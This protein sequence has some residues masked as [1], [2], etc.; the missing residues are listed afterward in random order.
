M[1]HQ[2]PPWPSGVGFLGL[3]LGGFK[4]KEFKGPSKTSLF[5]VVL[6][7]LVRS[8]SR[9]PSVSQLEL[10]DQGVHPHH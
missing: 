6:K 2:A 5:H 3:F 1:N 9:R 10:N 4:L 7:S 8:S